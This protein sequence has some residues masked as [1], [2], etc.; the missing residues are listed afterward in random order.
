MSCSVCT[1]TL[2]QS[3]RAKITCFACDFTCCKECVRTFLK[4]SSSL[5]KCMNCNAKFTMHFL[6]RHLNRSWVLTT[7][8]ETM[9]QI[10]TGVE[11]GK[12]SETQPYV[13]A[14]MERA[15]L[16]RV[17]RLYLRQM[18]EAKE[19][20]KKLTNA[21]HANQLR[22]RGETVPEYL[23]NELVDGPSVIIDAR[24]KFTMAC[25]LDGCRGFLSTQYKC[26]TC[27]QTVCSDCLVLKLDGH[28]CVESDRLTAEM[29]KKETKPC[30]TCGT[31]IYKIDGCD[32]MWCPN[33]SDAGVACNT[34]FSWKTGKI[35]TGTIHNPHYYEMMRSGVNLRNVGDIQCGGMP[36]IGYLTRTLRLLEK[37]E[38]RGMLVRMHAKLCEHVQYTAY[39]CRERIQAHDR[40]MRTHR[41]NYMMKK[42]TK[43]EFSDIVYKTEKDHQKNVDMYHILDLISISGIETFTCIMR[44]FPQ[45]REVDWQEY[46]VHHSIDDSIRVIWEH[47][48]QLHRVREYCNEQ[49]KQLS[50]TYHCTVQ[51]YDDLFG[52]T[53]SKYNI[54]G[55]K[56][57]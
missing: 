51:E 43:E 21:I 17:N 32:Q 2:N 25:P 24:K 34:A 18:Q 55:E 45:L 10:I 29:I 14:E 48:D 20:V 15:R 38:L 36:N 9:T 11:M 1:N 31:R 52:H 50:V 28:E 12:L 3:T 53:S 27:Q 49:L 30:P 6:V 19:R 42:I 46:L 40:I 7:Y 41:V 16:Q 39:T 5:P 37:N 13:E 4:T 47:L 33:K 23:Q 44:D 22:M 57:K 26:G 56:K 8:K 54:S 35:E